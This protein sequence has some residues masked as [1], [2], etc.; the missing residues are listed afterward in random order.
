[1]SRLRGLK[2][3]SSLLA[4]HGQNALASANP[5]GSLAT[6]SLLHSNLLPAAALGG[7][8]SYRDGFAGGNSRGDATNAMLQPRAPPRHV[9]IKCER[10]T[11]RRP[12]VPSF[13]VYHAAPSLIKTVTRRIVPEQTA[14][15]VERFGRYKKTLTPGIHI[16]IPVVRIP[17]QRFISRYRSR[18]IASAIIGTAAENWYLPHHPRVATSL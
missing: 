15:V 2:Q 9:G 4:L 13:A 18:A 5:G 11:S 6:A 7:I 16:L 14:F 17:V 12:A 1:M 10:G 8:R 3:L